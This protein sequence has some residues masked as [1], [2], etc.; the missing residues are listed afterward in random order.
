MPLLKDI[1][2]TLNKISMQSEK[3]NLQFEKTINSIK[4]SIKSIKDVSSNI[5]TL[6]IS[7]DEYNKTLQKS[8]ANLTKLL[9]QIDNYLENPTQ[10]EKLKLKNQIN[11]SNNYLKIVKNVFSNNKTSSDKLI[12]SYEEYENDGLKANAEESIKWNSRL[13]P[14]LTKLI[15]FFG[16]LKTQAKTQTRKVYS[17]ESPTPHPNCQKYYDKLTR[18]IKERTKT[19][20]L[21]D[22]DE[23]ALGNKR[24][25]LSNLE[26]FV[27]GPLN[28]EQQ[29]HNQLLRKALQM[30]QK[31]NDYTDTFKRFQHD[32]NGGIILLELLHKNLK[33]ATQKNEMSKIKEIKLLIDEKKANIL[34]NFHAFQTAVNDLGS[35]TKESNKE[36]SDSLIYYDDIL[37]N[38]RMK[39]N[40]D[41]DILEKKINDLI[42][43]IS[44]NKELLILSNVIIDRFEKWIKKNCPS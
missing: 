38:R 18:E 12:N 34:I 7:N 3:S 22:S 43:S 37:R 11:V 6:K 28:D 39:Y 25:E 8:Q 5:K 13:K 21:I 36:F 2:T 31:L 33:Y 10:E 1:Q 42:K 26:Y 40:D 19:E 44:D 41:S 30:T 23:V 16:K 35:I 9:K 4:A 32:N 15:N 24:I 27:K 17:S 20:E 14:S 29:A